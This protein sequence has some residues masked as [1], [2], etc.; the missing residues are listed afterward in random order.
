M[1]RAVLIC[2][3]RA[4]FPRWSSRPEGEAP[5]DAVAVEH[6][7]D[8]A[9]QDHGDCLARVLST[10]GALVPAELDIAAPV[11][12]AGADLTVGRRGEV[13]AVGAQK[14]EVQGARRTGSGGVSPCGYYESASALGILG[15][16]RYHYP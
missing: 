3:R 10:D 4:I 14:R 1:P 2:R 6:G 13:D 8:A 11:E 7:G 9:L 12:A 15:H 16:P 5:Q